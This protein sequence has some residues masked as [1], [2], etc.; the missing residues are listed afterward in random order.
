MLMIE[1]KTR[2]MQWGIERRLTQS[3]ETFQDRNPIPDRS[4]CPL[5]PSVQ[6]LFVIFA[7]FCLV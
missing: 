6:I 2:M 7:P 4:S 3:G 5:L 1:G